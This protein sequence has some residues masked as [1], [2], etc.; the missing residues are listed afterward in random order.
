MLMLQPSRR[1][2]RYTPTRPP[3]GKDGWIATKL[4]EFYTNTTALVSEKITFTGILLGFVAPPPPSPPDPLLR[5]CGLLSWTCQQARKK[6][7]FFQQKYHHSIVFG[8]VY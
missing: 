3:F 1:K 4:A 2:D 7:T 6:K 8:D 5:I